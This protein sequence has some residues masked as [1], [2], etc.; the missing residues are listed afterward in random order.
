MS[1]IKKLSEAIRNE[2]T[3][4]LVRESLSRNN[5]FLDMIIK[6]NGKRPKP[7]RWQRF[8]QKIKYKRNRLLE[9]KRAIVC[10]Y[11]HESYWDEE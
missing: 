11:K 9:L 7:T 6:E 1:E 5:V 4:D 8:C 3:A 2:Y 10:W